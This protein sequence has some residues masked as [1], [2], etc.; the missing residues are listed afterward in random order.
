[1]P[2]LV[3]VSRALLS[4]SD[5]RG[6]VEF[7]RALAELGVEIVSTGGS[8]RTLQ[9]A[10]IE[11]R[12][13]ADLTGFPEIMDGRVKTLH[14]KIHGGILARRDTHAHDLS[15]HA[16]GP[17][18]L[19]CV[20]LYPFEQT[21]ARE[22][23]SRD[24]AI[25]QIDIGG[26][27]LIRAGAKNHDWVVC[28][29]DP[30]QYAEVID[31]LRAHDGRTPLELRRRLAQAAFARTS[32]YD[33]HIA[34]YLSEG[35][36][37]PL[38]ASLTV[39]ARRVQEL[40]YGENPHQQGALYQTSSQVRP[41]IVDAAQLHG[42]ALSYNNIL[43]ADAAL[44]L[45]MDLHALEPARPCACVVKHTNP[46]GFSVADSPTDAVARAIA[47]DPLAAF[48]GI[49]ALSTPVDD[50][51]GERICAPDAFFEVLI[52]PGYA[53]AAL[54]RLRA[55]WKNLRILEVG[56]LPPHPPERLDL[57]SVAGGLL[58]QT[59]DTRLPDP[60]SWRHVA[61]PAP[62][63]DD[64][65]CA[66]VIEMGAR[67]LTSNAIAIG[68]SENDA[69]LLFGAGSGQMDRVTACRL[70]IEKAGERAHGAIAVSDA[71]FPFPDGPE[72]LID[73]GGRMIVHPGGSRRDQET[74]DL[75]ERRGVTCCLT[76][77]RRFRH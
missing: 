69:F 25:E 32:A 61:G 26:P 51:A 30:A 1:M 35:E 62:S 74:I 67:A 11:V 10:G 56:D 76:G 4:V 13:V 55:R 20:N 44:A 39:H 65:R 29:S 46:C 24:E 70:A 53:P 33:A 63:D 16:I 17:V 75:C 59:H 57:R 21:I 31:T 68:G 14:P 15:A 48:G 27:C 45:V 22:G 72:L 42:K 41:S 5:K 58:A 34:T 77:I 73:A 47:G 6:L 40:R 18:D 7:A 3:R 37:R 12:E 19:V 43:D 52:A 28:V 71:F 50:P 36:P 66:R 23:V 9:E 38:A 8:A 54:D 2:D 49:L 60:S 64:L